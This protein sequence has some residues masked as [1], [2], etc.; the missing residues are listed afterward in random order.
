MLRFSRQGG[1]ALSRLIIAVASIN[2]TPTMVYSF[3]GG[4][5]YRLVV[6]TELLFPS[7]SISPANGI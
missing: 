3:R 5:M 6:C 1:V 4:I 2:I 7:Q